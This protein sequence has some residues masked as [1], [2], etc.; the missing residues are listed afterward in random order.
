MSEQ[1]EVCVLP[2]AKTC[3][4]VTWFVLSDHS[5]PYG[6][7]L[8]HLTEGTAP[9]M[10]GQDSSTLMD[11]A[12]EVLNS[13]GQY[14]ERYLKSTSSLRYGQSLVSL[15]EALSTKKGVPEEMLGLFISIFRTALNQMGLVRGKKRDRG[16]PVYTPVTG[17]RD[18]V[19]SK[20]SF[21][22]D[23]TDKFGKA[24][25]LY[26]LVEEDGKALHHYV[27]SVPDMIEDML[28]IHCPIRLRV[29]RTDKRKGVL[30]C[31]SS[32]VK[33]LETGYEKVAKSA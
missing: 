1:S 23:G 20:W 8:K 30:Q 17:V 13:I 2:L 31:V 19:Y 16:V 24:F 32:L 9:E 4:Y 21:V 3:L 28:E 33:F 5:D 27:L 25:R 29:E 12:K 18:V 22:A 15:I 10:E 11:Y 7:V 6:A 14:A 26:S